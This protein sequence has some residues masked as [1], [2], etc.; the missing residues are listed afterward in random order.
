M[1]CVRAVMPGTK[2]QEHSGSEKAW[3]Y[4][5][6]DF[7]DEEQKPELFCIRFA[8]IERARPATAGPCHGCAA[9]GGCCWASWHACC[10]AGA[11]REVC[12][13]RMCAGAQEFK[14]AFEEAMAHNEKLLAEDEAAAESRGEET[15]AE[16]AARESSKKVPELA[17]LK[18]A[19]DV[20]LTS[21][22]LLRRRGLC[23][24]CMVAAG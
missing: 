2:L 20:C 1:V 11:D 9:H 21:G 23:C 5:T 17:C 22:A 6:V 24:V 15:P 10:C 7:A 16:A 14:K 8:S 4:S 12:V 3:V 19:L 18:A 13:L